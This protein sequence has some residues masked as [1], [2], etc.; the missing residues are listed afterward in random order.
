MVLIKQ[1]MVTCI[2]PP[3]LFECKYFFLSD[4]ANQ[5][6]FTVGNSQ[7]LT[8]L[9]AGRI[10]VFDKVITNKGGAYYSTNGAF[11][12][13]FDAVFAFSW[14]IVVHTGN[15]IN[16]FLMRNGNS[17]GLAQADGSTGI[18]NGGGSN[19]LIL[20]LKAG[21][22]VHLEVDSWG[23]ASSRQVFG[24]GHS[25]FSGWLLSYWNFLCNTIYI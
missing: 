19:T 10:L 17:Q 23:S 21:D 16:V 7:T 12:A 13:P 14:T 11:V 24:H 2:Y 6:Y 22:I 20:E 4:Q 1:Q 18:Q 25:S 8:N 5:V 9:R 15:K 3:S